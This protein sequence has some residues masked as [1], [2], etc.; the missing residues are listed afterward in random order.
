MFIRS[1]DGSMIIDSKAIVAKESPIVPNNKCPGQWIIM[2]GTTIGAGLI[3]AGYY[4]TCE[5][6][7]E[8]VSEIETWINKCPNKVFQM[9]EK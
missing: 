1:Q 8:V 2:A 4:D 6:A 7:L 9:P 3:T 5:R